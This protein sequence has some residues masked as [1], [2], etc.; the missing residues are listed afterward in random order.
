LWKIQEEEVRFT[1]NPEFRI[2][3]IDNG[4]IL[5][6]PDAMTSA[7][8]VIKGRCQDYRFRLTKAVEDLIDKLSKI[9]SK[10]PKKLFPD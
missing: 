10:Y 1:G 3:N 6:V 7:N 9:G 5:F 4:E 8:F 2:K